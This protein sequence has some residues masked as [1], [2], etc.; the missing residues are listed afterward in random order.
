MDRQLILATGKAMALIGAMLE[1][2]GIVTAE[3]FGG[4]LAVFA[5][6]VA[7]DEPEQGDDEQA[8]E[9][10]HRSQ[11]SAYGSRWRAA[12]SALSPAVSPL[13]EAIRSDS[14]SARTPSSGSTSRP[15]SGAG[16]AG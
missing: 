16:S 12:S 13:S 3:E 4:L 7:E 10:G 1:R 5:V 8:A 15:T 14:V 11:A 2:G 6:T 9:Q